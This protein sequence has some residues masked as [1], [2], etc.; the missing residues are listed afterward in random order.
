MTEAASSKGRGF[1][2]AFSLWNQPRIPLP[3]EPLVENF[4]ENSRVDR[5]ALAKVGRKICE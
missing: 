2:E 4:V 1:T 3:M 5:K